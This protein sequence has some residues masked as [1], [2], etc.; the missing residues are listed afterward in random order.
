MEQIKNKDGSFLQKME[1]ENMR[2]QEQ[3]FEQK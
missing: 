3:I 1:A 2:N